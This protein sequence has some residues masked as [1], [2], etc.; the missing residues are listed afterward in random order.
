[1]AEVIAHHHGTRAGLLDTR[2]RSNCADA[3]RNAV[4]PMPGHLFARRTACGAAT[5]TEFASETSAGAAFVPGLQ[6]QLTNRL[7]KG[8][9]SDAPEGH[10]LGTQRYTGRI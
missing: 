1:M 9:G 6:L 8:K 3:L 5:Q 4:A 7:A 2:F 10:S